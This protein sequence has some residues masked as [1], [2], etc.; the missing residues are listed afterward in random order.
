[1]RRLAVSAIRWYQR[2]LSPRKPAPTCRFSP[3][4]SEYAAQA[5]TRHGLVCGGWLALWRLLRCHPLSAGGHDPVPPRRRPA[6]QTGSEAHE[7]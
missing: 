4:C 6:S 3:S 5:I 1:M 2:R 7:I